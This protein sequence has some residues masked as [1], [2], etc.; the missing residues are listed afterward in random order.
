MGPSPFSSWNS[1]VCAAEAEDHEFRNASVRELLAS[2]ERNDIVLNRLAKEVNFE[3]IT[4]ALNS[5]VERARSSRL[6]M[7]KLP[8]LS[9]LQKSLDAMKWNVEAVRLLTS[10][11]T[12]Q[13]EQ[14]ELLASK[15][16]TPAPTS[17]TTGN[18]VY[19]IHELVYEYLSQRLN[20]GKEWQEKARS[21]VPA[22]LLQRHTRGRA[23]SS[24]SDGAKPAVSISAGR[25]CS[26]LDPAL[27]LVACCRSKHT[28]SG[29]RDT[30][31][32]AR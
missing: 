29:S 32:V 19:G 23:G 18:V 10:L 1:R 27:I 6:R 16:S 31:E 9:S 13:L 24:Q 7:L 25:I 3:A 17:S 15:T 30:S 2:P 4:K 11:A 5:L 28:D 14:L 20:P 21:L 22:Q 26:S 8:E 12:H